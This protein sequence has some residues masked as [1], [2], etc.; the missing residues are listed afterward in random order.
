VEDATPTL[1]ESL[2]IK[3]RIAS[4]T[5]GKVLDLACGIAKTFPHFIGV[6]NYSAWK[7]RINHPDIT[8][9]NAYALRISVDVIGDA[10]DLSMFAGASMD[11]VLASHI[12]Q[13]A[14][15]PMDALKEWWRVIKQGGHL[16]LYGPLPDETVSCMRANAG[17][18]DL[19]E[20][21]GEPVPFMVFRKRHDRQQVM[22]WSDPKPDK[23]VAITRYGAYGDCI[24]ATS[25]LT[26]LKA[27]GYHITF[28]TNP[29]GHEVI[30]HDP[31]IDRFMLVDTDQIPNDELSKFHAYWET[32]FDRFIE[33]SE[34]VEATMLKLPNMVPSW[35][36]QPAR[37]LICQADYLD[38]T[39]A[40]AGVPLPV[41]P[42]FYPTE[43]ESSEAVKEYNRIGSKVL[44]WCSDGSSVH[45]FW[46]WMDSAIARIL[47]MTKDWKIVTIGGEEGQ[48]LEFGWQD[49]PRVYRKCG[50]WTIRQ[51]L[52]FAQK[53]D[54]VV[55]PE[56][57]VMNAV[58]IEPMPK[59]V[60]LSHSAPFNLT[61][62]WVNTI[63]LEAQTGCRRCHKLIYKWGQCNR[64]SV[65]IDMKGRPLIIEGAECQVNITV[66]EFWSA[67]LKA[68][69]TDQKAA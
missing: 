29:R 64:K 50:R 45:K 35:W 11:A 25:I 33:L 13:D 34:T 69:N 47:T 18:W 8:P 21:E 12:L 67:F 10:F 1:G 22:V 6:D 56:T 24:Q 16:I 39:H 41:C 44:V 32:R 40:V 49:E 60:F 28:F 3:Y 19:L 17:G 23:T 30:K 20:N 52:A 61:S 37:E 42:K 31:R 63:S 15:R 48:V 43:K 5:R 54:L 27:E 7:G 62:H 26:G 57:G 58:C 53:A 2:K 55:G 66:D 4:Y 59:I 9:A 38:L 14:K 51:S 68:Q 46:P 65:K 36:P